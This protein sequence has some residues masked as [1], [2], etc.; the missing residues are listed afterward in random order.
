VADGIPVNKI[1][2]PREPRFWRGLELAAQDAGDRRGIE[3]IRQSHHSASALPANQMKDAIQQDALIPAELTIG[4]RPQITLAQS[5]RTAD[6]NAD[7]D[8]FGA[9]RS[10]DFRAKTGRRFELSVM[11]EVN[12]F[13]FSNDATTVSADLKPYDTKRGWYQI[14][15]TRSWQDEMDEQYAGIFNWLATMIQFCNVA[16]NQT[17]CQVAFE[18]DP[19]YQLRGVKQ[20]PIERIRLPKPFDRMDYLEHYE[21]MTALSERSNILQGEVG[22]SK[23]HMLYPTGYNALLRQ[24]H[25]TGNYPDKLGTLLFDGT[26]L[27]RK[28]TDYMAK[29]GIDGSP[30]ALLYNRNSEYFIRDMPLDPIMLA[31]EFDGK[32]VTFTF[33][34]RLGELSVT[35]SYAGL[36]VSNFLSK[37]L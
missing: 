4:Y 20:L 3:V 18:G 23:S 37:P 36:L 10:I 2:S 11:G 17:R 6:Y 33:V 21:W 13:L 22:I 29:A 7:L 1:I 15:I 30:A 34:M 25:P 8:A 26:T 35:N 28:S 5:S 16:L 24:L 9:D 31:P 19:V 32:K 12:R 27:K 14:G